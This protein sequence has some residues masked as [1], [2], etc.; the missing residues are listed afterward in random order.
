[1]HGAAG[2]QVFG[3]QEGGVGFGAVQAEFIVGLL[4]AAGIEAGAKLQAFGVDGDVFHAE[5]VKE[6]GGG[7]PGGAAAD[8][9]GVQTREWCHGDFL[10]G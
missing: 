8:D 7:Q 9:Q 3:H 4:V 2:G 5:A 10:G 6:D 1:M